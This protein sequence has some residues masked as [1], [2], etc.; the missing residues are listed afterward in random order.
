MASKKN[1]KSNSKEA[2]KRAPAKYKL[3]QVKKLAELVDNNKTIMFASIKGLP[4]KQFQ[5][6]KKSLEKEVFFI[7]AK[8]NITTRA[9]EFS[10]KQ[11]IHQ[12]KD[13]IK[14]DN[15]ILISQMDTFDLAGKLAESK[16]PVKAK[17]GQI[18]EMDINIEPGPTELV[19]GP[20]VSELGAL[21]L[22]IE[23]KSG[24][25]EIKEAKTIVK[26]GQA[27]SEAATN[28]MGKLNILPFSVGFIPLVAYD[29]QSNKIYTSL[30]IDKKETLNI[31]KNYFAKAKAFA[32]SINYISEDTI[33][34]LLAKAASHERVLESIVNIPQT[35]TKSEETKE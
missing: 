24:K 13:H 22:K 4:T 26:K 28:I 10:K 15:A 12:L 5:K 7:V 16:S 27:I 6:I 1:S 11:E 34:F 35:E 32:V 29:S 23:I 30:V 20:V 18:A 3:Q 31:L 8:K 14:E 21:G 25:I 19:A 2:A 33:G 9:I 17:V